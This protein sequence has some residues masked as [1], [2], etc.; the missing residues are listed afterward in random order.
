MSNSTELNAVNLFKVTGLVAVITG[1]GSGLGYMMAKA[2]VSNDAERVYIIGRRL[3]KL[4]EAAKF[5]DRIKVLQADVTSKDD[6]ANAAAHIKHEVGYI[7]LLVCNSGLT[8]PMVDGLPETPSLSQF[9]EHCWK[10]TT[11]E[12]TAPYEVNTTA[13]FF[14][15]VAFLG[16]LDAGNKRDGGS[17]IGSQVM[18]VA[19][20]AAFNRRVKTGFAY[21]ASK[22][23]T[24]HLAKSLSTYLA[25]YGI[26]VNAF[27]PGLFVTEMTEDEF[28]GHERLDPAG[29]VLKL[30][31]EQFPAGRSG[32]EED[33]AGSILYLASRAGAYL[34]GC[35][36]VID[37]GRLSVIPS[38]Y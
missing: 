22:A 6:L 17:N 30:D 3:Q 2:L 32:S 21:V 33:M 15:T 8:G 1:G 12:F 9:Q 4:E 19:S 5:H 16:L 23:G 26:R 24:I 25:P 11:Q 38:S 28:I 36:I 7:D 20:I 37:G 14:T 10:W 29:T 31:P 18:M 27:A 34:N 13:V 35:V